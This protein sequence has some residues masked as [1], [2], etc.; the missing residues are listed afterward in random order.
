LGIIGWGLERLERLF[1][2]HVQ[3][4]LMPADAVGFYDGITLDVLFIR[5]DITFS[6]VA[7]G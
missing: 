3:T 5:A 7:A 6:W 4:G 1:E 2:V